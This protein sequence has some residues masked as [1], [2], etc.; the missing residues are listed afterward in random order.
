MLTVLDNTGA[1]DT[2][3]ETKTIIVGVKGD[4]NHDNHI[5]PRRRRNCTPS[6]GKRRQ[7]LRSRR[8]PHNHTTSLDALMIMQAADEAI[9]L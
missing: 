5:I 8:E 1:T 9:T 4:L 2:E 7:G 3:T 6:R